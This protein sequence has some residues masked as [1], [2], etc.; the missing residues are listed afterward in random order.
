MIYDVPEF[1]SKY[2]SDKS[3]ITISTVASATLVAFNHSNRIYVDVLYSLLP[4]EHAISHNK[5]ASFPW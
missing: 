3:E 1:H 5:P 4:L 2:S